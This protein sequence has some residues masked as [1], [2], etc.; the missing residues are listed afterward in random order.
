MGKKRLYHVL[1][2]AYKECFYKKEHS[3]KV[4]ADNK[5]FQVFIEGQVFQI[6]NNKPYSLIENL[7][8]LNEPVSEWKIL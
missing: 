2:K 5:E 4:V 1:I 7:D 3:Q 8:V 6:K